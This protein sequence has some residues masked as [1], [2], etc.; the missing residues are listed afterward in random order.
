MLKFTHAV[1]YPGL[2]VHCEMAEPLLASSA[3]ADLHHISRVWLKCLSARSSGVE[4]GKLLVSHAGP[5]ASIKNCIK[6]AVRNK[7]VLTPVLEKIVERDNCKLFT[8]KDA[9][10]EQLV[11]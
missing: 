4:Q 7:F 9:Q 6:D 1:Q 3:P 5:N 8:L 11:L 2:R 10:A